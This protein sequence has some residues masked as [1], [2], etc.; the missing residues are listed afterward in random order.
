MDTKL[1]G[2]PPCLARRPR[3]GDKTSGVWRVWP[4]RRALKL[5]TPETNHHSATVQPLNSFL[6]I[7]HPGDSMAKKGPWETYWHAGMRELHTTNK[8]TQ[9]TMPHANLQAQSRGEPVFVNKASLE[10]CHTHSL[11]YHQWLE[12]MEQRPDSPQSWNTYHLTLFIKSLPT[13]NRTESRHAVGVIRGDYWKS[14]YLVWALK[15]MESFKRNRTE[16]LGGLAG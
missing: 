2:S 8:A 1:G 15:N 3:R 16:Y 14:W 5:P 12:W 6:L 10:L 4:T 9:R 7:Q 11:M 13:L